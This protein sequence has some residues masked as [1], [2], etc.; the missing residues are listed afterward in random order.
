MNNST[1]PGVIVPD[2]LTALI[3]EIELVQTT[4][5]HVSENDF[6]RNGWYSLPKQIQQVMGRIRF[7]RRQNDIAIKNDWK[8]FQPA[9]FL[10]LLYIKAKALKCL[11]LIG[12]CNDL[13]IDINS[14]YHEQRRN[15]YADWL[16]LVADILDDVKQL[17]DGLEQGRQ[18]AKAYIATIKQVIKEGE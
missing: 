6:D 12:Q 11:V 7:L 16:V 5:V 14:N 10:T 13:P 9:D 18:V 15:E 4:L 8:H 3:S 1:L 2:F 17:L